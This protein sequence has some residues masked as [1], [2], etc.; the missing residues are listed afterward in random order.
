MRRG[1]KHFKSDCLSETTFLTTLKL[2]LET[3]KHFLQPWQVWNFLSSATLIHQL[4]KKVSTTTSFRGN[5]KTRS[6]T[7][8]GTLR[9]SWTSRLAISVI[10]FA[11]FRHALS[12]VASRTASSP[13]IAKWITPAA[14]REL[15]Q[16]CGPLWPA[17]AG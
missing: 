15:L 7:S 1:I 14:T 10:L 6:S 11:S 3:S 4:W 8:R 5:K 12:V 9:T 2:S 13:R 16:Q 17:K